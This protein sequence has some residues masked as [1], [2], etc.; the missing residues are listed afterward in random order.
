MARRTSGFPE[1]RRGDRLTASYLST[2]LKTLMDALNRGDLPGTGAT[3]EPAFI[4]PIVN[5]SDE[6]IQAFGAV[7][8][9]RSTETTSPKLLGRRSF[10]ASPIA[11][12]DAPAIHPAIARQQIKAGSAGEAY[13]SGVC[14]ARLTDDDA[15]LVGQGGGAVIWAEDSADVDGYRWSIVRI[16]G[17]P[18]DRRTVE[19]IGGQ[20]SGDIACVLYNATDPTLAQSYDPDVDTD[21]PT[22]LGNAWLYDYRGQRSRR[23]L[24]RHDFSGAPAPLVAGWVYKVRGTRLLTIASGADSGQTLRVYLVTWDI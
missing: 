22:G 6:D 7:A 14:A 23:V 8:L 17:A 2:L 10:Q 5:T 11:S 13:V 19:V 18:T 16:G 21:Y 1:P 4:A 12:S 9:E 20:T 3:T 24:V 15:D